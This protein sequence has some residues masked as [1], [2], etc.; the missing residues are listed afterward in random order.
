MG[1]LGLRKFIDSCGCTRLLPVP[2]SDAE[3]TKEALRRH[4]VEDHRAGVDGDGDDHDDDRD[5]EPSAL[6]TAT[7][8]NGSR[9]G[10]PSRHHHLTSSSHV[11]RAA[12][13]GVAAGTGGSSSVPLVDHVLIDMNCIVHSCFHHQSGENMT[14]K[15]LIHEVLERLRVLVT[16]VVVPQQSLSFCFD[17]PAP[18]AKLQTQRLRRRKVSLLDAGD[19]QQLST[20][21]IT[22]GSLF[23]IE[24]ENAIASQFK[25]NRGRGFLRRLCPVYLHGTTVVGEGE[26]KIARALAFLAYGPGSSSSTATSTPISKGGG[27]GGTA[28]AVPTLR[29]GADDSVVVMGNDI[30]LVVTCLGATAFHNLSIISPSS[31]QLIRVSDIL[32][33][34]LKATS[35]TRGDAAFTPSQLPSIRI[36]FIFLFLLNG[37]DHYTG[38]GEV[39][40]SLWRRYR[41]VRAAYPHST[42]VSP[43]L[44][45]VDT[46]FLADV[47][48]AS[49]YA[50]SSSVEVGMNLLQS[51]LWSLYTVVTGVC[52]DYNHVPAPAAPQLCHLRAAAAHCQRTHARVRLPALQVNS[53]PLT[54]LETY[55]ALMPT[56]ATLPKSVVS[57]LHSRAA[58]QEILK[59]LQTSNDTATI[60]RAAKDAVA[61]S[62]QWLTTSEQYLREFTSPV[63]LNV[64]PPRRRLSRHEQHRMM[65]THGYVREEDPVPVV[66]PITMPEA[67]P[68]MEVPYPPHT[69]YLDFHCPF[70]A[71]PA[72]Q[73]GDDDSGGGAAGTTAYLNGRAVSTRPLLHPTTRAAAPGSGS[74][75]AEGTASGRAGQPKRVYLHVE[76]AE[77]AAQQR[78]RASAAAKLQ[79]A[80]DMTSGLLERGQHLTAPQQRRMQRRLHRLQ[81]AETAEL[82]TQLATE[83]RQ[84]AAQTAASTAGTEAFEAE[85]RQFLGADAS[86]EDVMALM[87]VTAE[88]TDGVSGGD[89]SR[90]RR[91]STAAGATTTSTRRRSS[92]CKTGRAAAIPDAPHHGERRAR[93]ERGRGGEGPSAP[94]SAK[95]RGRRAAVKVVV[96]R[97][98]DD[99]DDGSAL[100]NASD[101]VSV[102]GSP[103]RRGRAAAPVAEAAAKKRRR[104]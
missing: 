28:P 19:A 57:G 46:D 58:H 88:D 12:A 96:S 65:A 27:G 35:A 66:H 95:Q 32:Y 20:L 18:I 42:L 93:S 15:Q 1:L 30:D 29:C 77:A 103:R 71:T 4:R 13:T 82:R 43:T 62:A 81:A 37:G 80:L 36:D 53:K 97:R 69:T 23:M 47:V 74:G 8:A 9:A 33:R 90:S 48:Q 40:M 72:A 51:A 86:P 100:R 56:E 17:G 60:A 64:N 89:G 24:L 7:Y 49:D 50:G 73:S 85:L 87:R 99:D 63:Q 70:D 98:D 11:D 16:E 61:V 5:D 68:Y 31:L 25:L 67:P 22:A 76:A 39:A 101:G 104:V 45:A 59:T 92:H 84:Y 83:D 14:R 3:A 2:Q 41:S 44:D 94:E 91:T 52:P 78:E 102:S 6:Y 34:W 54:P 21:A 75:A 55:V 79:R 10:K 26:A 38:A